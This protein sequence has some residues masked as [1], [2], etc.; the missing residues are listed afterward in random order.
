[1][2][3]EHHYLL[4]FL[5]FFLTL[6]GSFELLANVIFQIGVNNYNSIVNGLTHIIKLPT[7]KI[8]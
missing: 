3:T 8:T 6:L 7:T 4:Y 1:M 2:L 5:E